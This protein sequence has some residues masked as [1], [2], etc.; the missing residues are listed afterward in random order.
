VKI[1]YPCEV[2]FLN[3]VQPHNPITSYENCL[4]GEESIIAAIINRTTPL[5]EKTQIRYES[6]TT[7]E[8][9]DTGEWQLTIINFTINSF[10]TL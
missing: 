2:R 1:T 4:D 10:F 5:Y 9:T 3:V 7:G 8:L 6:S